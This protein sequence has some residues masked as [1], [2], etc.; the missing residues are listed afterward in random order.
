[1]QRSILKTAILQLTQKR[2]FKKQ[3]VRVRFAPSPTGYL[4]LGGLRTALYNYLFARK[5]NGTFILRIE[6]TDQTRVVPEAVEQL[7]DDLLWAGII[8]DEDPIRFGPT[9][10][11]VQSERLEI[12]GEQVIKLLENG[13]AYHCF[14]SERRLEML[15]REAAR[16]SQV[17][18][19][20]NRCRHLSQEN[21]KE[22]LKN[23]EKHCIRFKLS[24]TPDPFKDMVYGDITF[25]VSV[26]EGDP[27]IMKSDG[28]PTYH[29][30][31]VVD[32]HL[33]EISH[34]LRGVEWQI[35]TPKHLLLYKAFGWTP[36]QF[37]HLPLILNSDGSKLSKR[38]D[39]I[40]VDF[41]R[42]SGIFPIALINY[43]T[44]AGGG[45]EREQGPQECYSYAD[46]IK[47][48][49][50]E[51]INVNSSK[52][53]PEKLLEFNQLELCSLLENE[54]NNKI[55]VQSV[56]KLVSDSFP[57][58]KADGSLKLDED[59]ILL[60][61]KWAKSRI[62]K[63]TD[64]VSPDLAFLWVVPPFSQNLKELK[65]AETV[66][67][68]SEK[69][70]DVEENNFNKDSLK[71]Y[72]KEFANNNGVPFAELMRTLRSLLSGLKDGPGVAEMMEILGRKRTVDR[73]KR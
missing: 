24:P 28:Y 1:M 15:R 42:K 39:D 14:C 68:L 43:I 57:E 35:S 41:Y 9:G 12:Y 51:K 67:V 62:N 19:Y 71:N 55:F 13:S 73:L 66:Q 44:H 61:L 23:G 37:G 27:I 40:R 17:P 45:F 33:M 38:Q 18:K 34:V 58:R 6:D 54:K 46:L 60:T 2:F 50:V 4:H 52:L 49:S 25:D 72:L 64:L 30:A 56:I 70:S 65:H 22:K 63:L 8:P 16:A 5:N 10:P 26:S 59:H 7:H 29:F 36:P 48:F 53:R 11:Y 32:D 69:L 47:Q 31:N 21:V 20:D 3:P